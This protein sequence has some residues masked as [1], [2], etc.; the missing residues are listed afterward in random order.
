MK[1]WSINNSWTLFLD[2]DGVIN[3]RIPGEYIKNV[4]EFE[5][6]PGSLEVMPLLREKF[7]RLF[8]VTNQK[9]VGK[10]L[11]TAQDLEEVH[12]Y[13]LAAFAEKGVV[14]DG[15][16]AATAAK[17]TDTSNHKPNPGMAL[18]AQTA[19][20]KVDFSKSVMVGDSL[21]DMEFGLRL[22][23][24]TVLVAGKFEDEAGLRDLE[25]DLRVGNLAEFGRIVFDYA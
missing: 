18:Q 7:G 19:F 17:L 25:V 10:G 22:D 16:Y 5:F 13:M 20:P 9:G 3:R 8:I 2:R 14:P 15:V 12:A 23:M 21:T 11:M 6:L 4:G 24:R 1:L